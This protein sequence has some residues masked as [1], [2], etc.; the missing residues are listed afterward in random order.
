MINA[1][2]VAVGIVL[3]VFIFGFIYLLFKN[4]DALRSEHYSLSKLAMEKGL[5]GDSVRGL[6]ESQTV[7]STATKSEGNSEEQQAR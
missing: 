7:L 5:L 2:A 1:L 4:P 6:L 3:A